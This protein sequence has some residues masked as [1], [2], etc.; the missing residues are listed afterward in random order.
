M[1]TLTD[2]VAEALEKLGDVV[3][4]DQKEVAG[5]IIEG[6]VIKG[7]LESRSRSVDTCHQVGAD[8]DTAHK[9]A[10]AIR[11]EN[12]ALITNLKAMY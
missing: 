10:T 1:S 2:I 9:I 3:A 8:K 12:D 4:A 6:A 5:K 7:I 11:Q